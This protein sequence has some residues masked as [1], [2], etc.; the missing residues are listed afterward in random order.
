MRKQLHLAL[1]LSLVS[2]SS[3]LSQGAADRASSRL[4]TSRAQ[5][6][7]R[8]SKVGSEGRTETIVREK[9]ITVPVPASRGPEVKGFLA[10]RTRKPKTK[11]IV[12]RETVTVTKPAPTRINPY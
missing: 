8:Y 11:R 10:E 4:D 1:L 6:E 9:V 2:A 7:S 5:N 3:A 12:V